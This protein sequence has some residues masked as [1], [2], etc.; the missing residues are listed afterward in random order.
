MPGA[1]LQGARSMPNRPAWVLLYMFLYTINVSNILTCNHRCCVKINRE[2]DIEVEL[3]GEGLL[4]CVT[5]LARLLFKCNNQ[6]GLLQFGG[7]RWS[8]KKHI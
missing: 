2:S 4:S 1:P 5:L 7:Q 8:V 3:A 6:P